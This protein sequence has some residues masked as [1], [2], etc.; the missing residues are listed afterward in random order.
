MYFSETER[1]GIKKFSPLAY[2]LENW[3]E[4]FYLYSFFSLPILFFLLPIVAYFQGWRI[5]LLLFIPMF[6]FV[7]AMFMRGKAKDI[8]DKGGFYYDYELD[9]TMIRS[10][11]R[12]LNLLVLR[13]RDIEKTKI[14]YEKFSLSFVK[15]Q[16]GEGSVHYATKIGDLVLEL[17]PLGDSN[18]DNNRLGFTV[19]SSKQILEDEEIELVSQYSFDGQI[20]YVIVD[21]D[22][23]K[24]E[25]VEEIYE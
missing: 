24:V 11:I 4:M 9:T 13:C 5:L 16:H 21:P 12:R 14:F 15:E 8:L 17:Y 10:N 6:F 18:V 25:I 7:L 22:G 2:Y 3:G 19:N 20:Y 1:L 23:R